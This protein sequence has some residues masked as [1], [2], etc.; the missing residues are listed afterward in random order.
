MRPQAQEMAARANGCSTKMLPIALWCAGVV[1]LVG[2]LLLRNP[3]FLPWRAV[4][5]VLLAVSTLAVLTGMGLRWHQARAL[6]GIQTAWLLG[7]WLATGTHSLATSRR[8]A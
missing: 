8:P 7:L 2:A 4:A 6:Y 5:G 1:A 3:L